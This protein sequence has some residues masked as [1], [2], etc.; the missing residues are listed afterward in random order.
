MVLEMKGKPRGSILFRQG[1]VQCGRRG[2][3]AHLRPGASSAMSTGKN[4]WTRRAAIAGGVLAVAGWVYVAPRLGNLLGHLRP[5]PLSYRDLPGL[6]PFRTLETTGG[7]SR[8]SDLFVGLD[9]VT[10]MTPS[11]E[12]RVAAVRADP[13]TALFGSQTDSRLPIAVFSDFNCPNCRALDT[14]LH[15]YDA[16]HPK[17][18]RIVR[19]ELPLLGDASVIASQAVLAADRQGGYGAMQDR[20]IRARLVTD[21]NFVRAMAEQAGLD[22]QRLIDDM[23]SPGIAA[24]LDQSRAIARVFGFYGTPAT[25][26]GR[27]VFLGAIPEAELA[28]IVEAELAALPLACKP[29]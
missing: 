7:V 1:P 23:Q 24:M 14:L 6:A 12:A 13:C 2:T 10:T 19:H 15:D 27:T 28:Q 3:Q 26:I 16:A 8:G 5:T 25:V 11:Q 17:T 29:V 4:P 21:L 9:G 20:L 18:I 22:G